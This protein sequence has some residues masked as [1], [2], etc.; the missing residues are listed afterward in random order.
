L[1]LV[2]SRGVSGYVIIAFLNWLLTYILDI[3]LRDPVDYLQDKHK[4]LPAPANEREALREANGTWFTKFDR[5]PGWYGPSN[6]PIDGMHL[7]DLGVTPWI[8]KN[9]L[10]RPGLLN[11]RYRN[12]PEHDIPHA[13]GDAFLART[14]FPSHCGRAPKKVCPILIVLSLADLYYL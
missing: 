5:L 9:I 12:Q 2:C 10:I 11:A 13:R 7:F 1:L 4:W 6:T 14:K 8:A 3:E